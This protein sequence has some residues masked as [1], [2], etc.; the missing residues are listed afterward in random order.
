MTRDL[1]VSY[2]FNLEEYND[3]GGINNSNEEK[4]W[5]RSCTKNTSAVHDIHESSAMAEVCL[6][7]KPKAPATLHMSSLTNGYSQT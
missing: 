5:K 1:F 7:L 3:N 6:P 2:T 4:G